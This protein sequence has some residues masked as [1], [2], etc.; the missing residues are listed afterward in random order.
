VYATA[1]FLDG[2]WF[3]RMQWIVGAVAGAQLLVFDEQTAYGIQ[4]FGGVMRRRVFSPGT[5]GYRLF[6]AD[7]ERPKAKGPAPAGRSRRGPRMRVHWSKFVSVRAKA[8]A[9]AGTTLF[10][11]GAPDIVPP[12]DPLAAF[13]G[14]L[15]SV[16]CAFDAKSGKQLSELKLD[17]LPV[18]DGMARQVIPRRHEMLP[19]KFALPLALALSCCGCL[20]TER[21]ARRILEATGVKGGLVV[22]VG[23][24]EG[25]LTAALRAGPAYLVQGLD[26]NPANVAAA[27]KRFAAMGIR[28]GSVTAIQFD[29]RH[30]P[31]AD[32]TVNLLVAEDPGQLPAEE[33]M[34][35]LVPGGVAHLRKEG[36]W[37]KAVRRRPKEMDDWT[38]FLH[39]PDNNAVS[40]DTRVGF[41]HHIQWVG[42]P[43]HS[44]DHE[45]ATSMHTMVSAGGRLFYVMDEAPRALA[46]YLP[47]R[48]FLVCRDA[49]NGVVLW[50]R[51]IPRWQ[52]HLVPKRTSIASSRSTPRRALS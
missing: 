34:R 15:G 50:K 5:K 25:K 33:I 31:Y 11:C 19:R 36:Q 40:R 45:L 30:L 37:T 16:L 24:G 6:A 39:G 48:W 26:T 51:P 9:L 12:D 4:A 13:E 47:S 41:P 23:C 38:H 29:G 22:H 3:N 1:G 32:Q 46:Y 17:S 28:D 14:K 2:N 52:P 35:V 42:W 18:W 21:A 10:A 7:L 44:R 49:F 20:G 27:R 8:L 43:R